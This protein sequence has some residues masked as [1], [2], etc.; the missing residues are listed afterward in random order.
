MEEFLQHHVN[1]KEKV[2]LLILAFCFVHLETS[3]L[4]IQNMCGS[5]FQYCD[6]CVFIETL[7][8]VYQWINSV[9]I[10]FLPLCS[11]FG[12]LH[13]YIYVSEVL[14]VL[15]WTKDCL[16]FILPFWIFSSMFQQLI[17]CF[18]LFLIL[19]ISCLYLRILYI[20]VIMHNYDQLDVD[21]A[22]LT[23]QD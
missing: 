23:C 5:F 8:Y 9:N 22:N 14:H 17:N 19:S 12:F 18:I 20:S 10:A 6:N 13:V 11:F 3:I 15:H 1:S 4:H 2:S 16:N 21:L 7:N